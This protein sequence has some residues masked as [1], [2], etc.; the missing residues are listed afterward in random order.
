MQTRLN[1]CRDLDNPLSGVL[2]ARGTGS[3]LL[4]GAR[5][6]VNLLRSLACAFYDSPQRDQQKARLPQLEFQRGGWMSDLDRSAEYGVVPAAAAK[7]RSPP[8]SGRGEPEKHLW[9]SVRV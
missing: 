6:H 7:M 4:A 1:T 3:V 9:E 2:D 5:R 8:D